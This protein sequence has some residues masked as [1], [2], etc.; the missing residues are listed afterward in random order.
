[1]VIQLQAYIHNHPDIF[2][3]VNTPNLAKLTGSYVFYSDLKHFPHK[4]HVGIQAQRTMW[5]GR[6]YLLQHVL[7]VYLK[8][9]VWRPKTALGPVPDPSRL[10]IDRS[11]ATIIIIR[12]EN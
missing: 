3:G 4:L 6:C 8:N 9:N 1:M 7:F 11:L 10:Y 5:C 12:L 2:V